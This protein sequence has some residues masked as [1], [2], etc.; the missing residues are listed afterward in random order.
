MTQLY[1]FV[2][3]WTLKSK[4]IYFLFFLLFAW[5]TYIKTCIGRTFVQILLL[6]LDLSARCIARRANVGLTWQRTEWQTAVINPSDRGWCVTHRARQVNREW[7][8]RKLQHLRLFLSDSYWELKGLS[9]VRTVRWVR[10]IQ[11]QVRP[12]TTAFFFP[13][14]DNRQNWHL[15]FKTLNIERKII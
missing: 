3:Y 4:C 7:R 1:M 8:C 2:F 14:I 12:K 13:I 11:T 6:P 15:G 10:N 9:Q 5:D